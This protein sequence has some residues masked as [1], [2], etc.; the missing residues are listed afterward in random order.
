MMGARHG[1]TATAR[2]VKQ[3][4]RVISLT[5]SGEY[6]KRVVL[7]KPDNPIKFLIDEITNSPFE[8]GPPPAHPA[9]LAAEAAAAESSAPEKLDL[10]RPLTKVCMRMCVCVWFGSARFRFASQKQMER[11][12]G[13]REEGRRLFTRV[14]ACANRSRPR[15]ARRSRAPR[16]LAHP[17]KPHQTHPPTHTHTQ[18]NPTRQPAI[19]RNRSRCCGRSSTRSTRRGAAR[20]RARSC[21]SRSSRTRPSC[22]RSWWPRRD[23]V[24]EGGKEGRREGG[25]DGGKEGRREGRTDV[26]SPGG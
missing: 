3:R 17:Q 19:D 14:D 6:L 7:H 12:E 10:R 1:T 4:T 2:S 25:K 15:A 22:S 23:G 24:H 13:G 16:S 21:W 11:R 20:S 5:L 8:P 26:K 9:D 18:L